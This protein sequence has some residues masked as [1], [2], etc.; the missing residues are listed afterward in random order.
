MP[1]VY[2]AP[3]FS[4]G[5]GVTY[6]G[7][8]N[9]E[10]NTV[11]SGTLS[12]GGSA[13]GATNAG[14]YTITPAGLTNAANANYAISFANGTLLITPSAPTF[15]VGSTANPVGYLA[16]VGFTATLPANAGGTA[17]FSSALGPISTN[18]LVGGAASSVTITNLPRGTNL[19]TVVYSG[20]ANYLA[21]TNTLDQ[22]VTNHPP[23]AQGMLV[24]RTAGLPLE[25]LLSDLATN[26]SDG[27]GDTVELTAIN[28]TTTNGVT[29]FPIGLTTN[30]DGSYVLTNRAFL[31]YLNSSNVADQ[32]S[33]T[34]S[35]GNG[36]TATGLIDISVENN[37]VGTNSITSISVGSSNV[38][39]A[40]GVPG[41]VYVT[42]RSTNLATWVDISTNTA[43]TNGLI[44]VTDSFIDLGGLAPDQAY[45]RLKWSGN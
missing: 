25:I 13:Q 22:T 16:A 42:E 31:G 4:G 26:W 5:V 2:G 27:D 32:I 3:G 19:I 29:V 33:Y 9:G 7:F 39:A 21:E 44:N 1:Y 30:L 41:L 8:V 45:Y 36:G 35:D 12:Y 14:T 24:T 28:F 34:I 15:T 20:D 37:V 18:T 43:G 11:L 17:T 38:L 10:T 23:V 6:S 40:Y